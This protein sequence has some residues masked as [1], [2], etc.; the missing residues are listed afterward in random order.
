[1]RLSS[2]IVT[3]LSFRSLGGH[4]AERFRRRVSAHVSESEDG[5][6]RPLVFGIPLREFFYLTEKVS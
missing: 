5:D 2:K 4:I 3:F 1:V 6:D